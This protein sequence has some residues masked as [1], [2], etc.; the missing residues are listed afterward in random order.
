M[1]AYNFNKVFVDQVSGL[2]KL[3]TVRADRKR[4]ARPGE[5]VQLYHGMRTRVCRKLVDPDPV[6]TAVRKVEIGVSTLI[7]D[8][9]A[10]IWIDGIPLRAAEIEEFARADGFAPEHHG[11]VRIGTTVLATARYWMGRFW[12]EHHGEGRFEGVVVKWR[13]N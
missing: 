13:P 4:H 6:C 3:Q 12:L 5:Q 10:S 8:M 11:K 9:I 7:D 2:T 1:V